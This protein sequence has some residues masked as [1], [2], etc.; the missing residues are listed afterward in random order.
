MH[1]GQAWIINMDDVSGQVFNISRA[2]G[3]TETCARIHRYVSSRCSEDAVA[4][5]AN[6]ARPEGLQSPAAR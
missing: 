6:K 2:D 3:C 4:A 1:A 5:P